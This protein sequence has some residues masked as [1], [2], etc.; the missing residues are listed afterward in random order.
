MAKEKKTA[1]ETK[2]AV[3]ALEEALRELG[4]LLGAAR[5]Y[6]DSKTQVASEAFMTDTARLVL[7]L[8]GVIN[9]LERPRDELIETVRK[10]ATKNPTGWIQA[11]TVEKQFLCWVAADGKLKVI[12]VDSPTH[13]LPVDDLLSLLGLECAI[14]FLAVDYTAVR[15]AAESNTL[16]NARDELV[17]IEEILK[18]RVRKARAKRVDINSL[19]PAD[20]TPLVAVIDPEIAAQRLEEL[21]SFGLS[22]AT[23]TALGK[24]GIENAWQLSHLSGEEIA[25]LDGIGPVR[26]GEIMAAIV[27]RAR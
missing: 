9:T 21:S 7:R 12:L 26:A 24:N 27:K 22:A 3:Q 23:V 5:S 18:R 25:A 17:P 4:E 20:A 8:R 1:K 10:Y 13:E 16:R 6:A 2:S 15:K 19:D 11:A 14:P